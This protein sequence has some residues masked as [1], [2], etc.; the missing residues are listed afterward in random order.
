MIRDA[1]R[2]WLT[3]DTAPI[4]AE[5][6]IRLDT[7]EVSYVLPGARRRVNVTVSVHFPDGVQLSRS[8][9]PTSRIGSV[10]GELLGE[11]VGG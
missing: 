6:R 8:G 3:R 10:V 4:G 5:V 2:Y 7:K 1:L 9:V 11:V